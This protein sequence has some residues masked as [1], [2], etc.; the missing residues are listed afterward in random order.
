VAEI[1]KPKSSVEDEMGLIP[2]YHLSSQ[3]MN[4]TLFTPTNI[5]VAL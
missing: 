4:A 5:R 1:E 3:Q 2:R